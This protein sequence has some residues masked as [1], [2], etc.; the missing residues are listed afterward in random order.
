MVRSAHL[1]YR[2]K[3]L[4]THFPRIFVVC[5]YHKGK[6]PEISCL[7]LFLFL[8]LSALDVNFLIVFSWILAM[9]DAHVY[10]QN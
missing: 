9:L 2:I 3:I 10:C 1:I 4:L 6:Q 7:F 5:V 8:F